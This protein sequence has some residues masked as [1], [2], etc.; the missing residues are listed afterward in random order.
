MANAAERLLPEFLSGRR[1]G[2]GLQVSAARG[3]LETHSSL[4]CQL[5]T[6]LPE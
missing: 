6:W 5:I 1:H 4:D 3:E 2:R